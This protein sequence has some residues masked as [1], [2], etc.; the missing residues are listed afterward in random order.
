MLKGQLRSPP[1][2]MWAELAMNWT[3]LKM[4][5]GATIVAAALLA[6]SQLWGCKSNPSSSTPT[7]S[8]PTAVAPKTNPCQDFWHCM[9]S[10]PGPK[11]VPCPQ[12]CRETYPAA[13][14]LMEE[15]DR[16]KS[17]E[18][19]NKIAAGRLNLGTVELGEKVEECSKVKCIRQRQQCGL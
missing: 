16:C 9:E 17:E 14:P 11:D 18:C 4:T 12:W 8:T 6:G 19:A 3:R 13:L 15:L 10:C 1:A 5:R 2:A 7:A